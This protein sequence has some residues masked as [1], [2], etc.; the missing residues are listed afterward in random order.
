MRRV[1]VPARVADARPQAGA[2]VTGA[3][4]LTMGTT[5]SVSV[6]DAP[7]GLS[8]LVQEALDGVVR[9][10]SHWDPDSDLSR[11]NAAPADSRCELPPDLYTVV[12]AGVRV[13]RATNGAFNPFAGELVDLWGFG[14]HGRHDAP[15]FAAPSPE[16]AARAAQCARAALDD[17]APSSPHTRKPLSNRAPPSRTLLQ[18]G[19]VRLDL[20]AIA[21]GFGVDRVA[22]ALR[23]AGCAHFLVEVGGE[24]RG[25]GVKPDGQP[26]W[27]ALE[28][29]PGSTDD[30]V[31]ALHGLSIATSGD[32]RKFFERG[33]R[34]VAHTV[35]PRTGAALDNGVAAVTVFHPEC[36]LADALST[37]LSVLGPEEGMRFAEREGIPARMLVRSADGF[38]EHASS[39]FLEMLR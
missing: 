38:V 18:P 22:R 30:T 2:A 15:D 28:S 9:E 4:G 8:A 13:G 37:A 5:W 26:W 16:R 10:M 21:K 17:A 25:E 29:P 6:V 3:D 23:G 12:T 14:A 39:R 20:S 7:S 1:L 34:R 19:G 33:G 35:D 27:V 36:M 24:L 11:Y 32:Y 31:V